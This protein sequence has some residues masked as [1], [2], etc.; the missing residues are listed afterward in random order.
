M[1]KLNHGSKRAPG[2]CNFYLRIFHIFNNSQQGDTLYYTYPLFAGYTHRGI[3][4]CHVMLLIWLTTRLFFDLKRRLTKGSGP[5]FIALH[6]HHNECDGVSNHQ[7]HDCLLTRLFRRRSKK[8]SKL[9]VS[10]LCEGN[11]SATGEFPP[12]RASNADF[13]F[14]LMTS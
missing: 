4:E 9:P 12:Q 10:G 6:W 5:Y 2:K 11:L 7:P 3:Y 13:F 1:I 8:N 14:H